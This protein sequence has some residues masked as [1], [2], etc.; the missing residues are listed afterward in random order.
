MKDGTLAAKCSH[1]N[2]N[3]LAGSGNDVRRGGH[4]RREPAQGQERRRQL[5]IRNFSRGA[6]GGDL[7][8][9]THLAYFFVRLVSTPSFFS[10]TTFGTTQICEAWDA[11]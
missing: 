10:S 8:A 4:A 6:K 2:K 11:T 3:Y 1:T 9:P 7:K 5:S